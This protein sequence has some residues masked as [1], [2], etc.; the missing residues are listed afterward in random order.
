MD[1]KKDMLYTFI[2]F[3]SVLY[4]LFVSY[5]SINVLIYLFRRAVISVRDGEWHH[6]CATWRNT[7]GQNKIF[8][9]GKLE[10][11]GT[12]LSADHIIEKGGVVVLGQEQDSLG[13]GFQDNQALVGKIAN[14][15][16]WDTILPLK[17]IVEMS[18]NCFSRKG[19]VLSWEQFRSDIRGT[20]K[21]HEPSLCRAP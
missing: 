2:F 5:W 14:L 16:L 9:D 12:G 3:F 21:V 19:N 13:G 6:V 18:K 7:D 8:I 15:N 10:E 11:N 17:E 1:T 20:V 4:A